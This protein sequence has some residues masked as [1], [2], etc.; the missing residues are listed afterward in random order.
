M[1]RSAYV[2]VHLQGAAVAIIC[3]CMYIKCFNTLLK[4]F[5]LTVVQR[6]S[7]DLLQTYST[8]SQS[9]DKE[10]LQITSA[11]SIILASYILLVLCAEFV[12]LPQG[13]IDIRFIAEWVKMSRGKWLLTY[14]TAIN[15]AGAT[16]RSF[17]PC[18][19]PSLCGSRRGKRTPE[20]PL[21]VLLEEDH[22]NA[23]HTGQRQRT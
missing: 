14:H 11:T 22:G 5:L 20:S 2:T 13:S 4:V 17:R 21:A 7:H 15:D 23:C 19:R 8:A 12:A 18:Q 3:F 9:R 6:F 16:L 10:K 1:Q